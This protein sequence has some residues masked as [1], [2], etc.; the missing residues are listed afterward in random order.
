MSV[1]AKT[2]FVFPLA[3]FAGWLQVRAKAQPR[4]P[5]LQVW[6]FLQEVDQVMVVASSDGCLLLFTLIQ[7]QV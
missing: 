4:C 1:C 6:V 7:V 3:L 5:N 2:K